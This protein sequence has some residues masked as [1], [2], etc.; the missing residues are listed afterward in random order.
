MTSI[1]IE[2][3]SRDMKITPEEMKAIMGGGLDPIPFKYKLM[4]PV[5]ERIEFPVQMAY[6][7]GFKN[8]FSF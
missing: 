6:R 2:D 3:L 5:D 8:P 1:K 7:I 4:D